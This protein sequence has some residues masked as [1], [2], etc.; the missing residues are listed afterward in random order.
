MKGEEGMH[1]TYMAIFKYGAINSSFHS[2][3]ATICVS[4]VYKTLARLHC[5]CCYIYLAYAVRGV[6]IYHIILLADLNFAMP[7]RVYVVH[8][9]FHIYKSLV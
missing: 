4:P 1:R 8:V 3:I 5:F 9:L 7:Y 6:L 2:I